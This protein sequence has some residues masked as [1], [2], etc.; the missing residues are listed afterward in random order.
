LPSESTVEATRPTASSPEVLQISTS[1][2]GNSYSLF[3]DP[4]TE[5]L[6]VNQKSGKTSETASRRKSSAQPKKQTSGGSDTNDLMRNASDDYNM[7][8]N[9]SIYCQE[10]TV[11]GRTVKANGQGVQSP[12]SPLIAEVDGTPCKP[13][14]RPRTLRLREVKSTARSQEVVADRAGMSAS[15][16]DQNV[17]KWSPSKPAQNDVCEK[18][19]CS[20]LESKTPNRDV[21]V[22]ASTTSAAREIHRPIHDFAVEVSHE[23]TAEDKGKQRKCHRRRRRE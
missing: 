17:N 4:S 12:L 13:A 16:S 6:T 1:D 22:V 7:I 23:N 9:R 8:R 14:V 10:V 15:T 3:N 19:I 20:S 2:N 11:H 5:Q 21:I 18:G